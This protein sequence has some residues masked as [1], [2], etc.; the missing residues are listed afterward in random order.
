LQTRHPVGRRPDE[1]APAARPAGAA[2]LARDGAGFAITLDGG[3]RLT[4]ELV[5]IATPPQTAARLLSGVVG[6]A[7][8]RIGELR[9][10]TAD[11]VGVVV[12]AD[13]VTAIPARR[14]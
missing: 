14:S 10:A 5:A 2:V 12:R 4:A 13:Q 11:S 9:E 1:R 7:A 3:E 8:A 6:A